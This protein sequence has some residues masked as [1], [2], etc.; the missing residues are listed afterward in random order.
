MEYTDI[1]I[2]PKLS[3]GEFLLMPSNAFAHSAARGI[4]DGKSENSPLCLFSESGCGKTHLL[5][6]I[7]NRYREL[8]PE[9]KVVLTSVVRMIENYI[10]ALQDGKIAEFRQRYR[11]A[12]VLLIDDLE[13]LEKPKQ[14]QGELFN[15]IN[16][17]LS[18]KKLL[19]FAS[20]QC[21]TR[22]DLAER[23]IAR[24]A[25]GLV[26]EIE[27]F[28]PGGRIEF[29]K[30]QFQ[31]SGVA[32]S[33]TNLALIAGSVVGNGAELMRAV[34]AV[35]FASEPNDGEATKVCIRKALASC[36]VEI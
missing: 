16:A 13:A 10:A 4:A 2:D 20:D 27:K 22:L 21:P 24:I 33:D 25:S 14:F 30:Y 7:A 18:E 35:R 29:L 8:N 12:D 1:E 26:V 28:T 17:M 36:G 5:N 19:V 31:K 3:F 15:T 11:S 6:A 32:V 9:K 34:K 23:L